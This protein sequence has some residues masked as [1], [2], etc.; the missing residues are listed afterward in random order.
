MSIHERDSSD[1]Y[2]EA[3]GGNALLCIMKKKL[4]YSAIRD[5]PSVVLKIN[6]LLGFKVYEMKIMIEELVFSTV[7]QRVVS[8]LLRFADK[9]GSETEAEN[10]SN[11]RTINLSLSHSDI[12]E[13]VGSTRETT[14]AALDRLKNDGIIELKRKQIFIVDYARLQSLMKEAQSAER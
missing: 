7:F 2:A 11:K 14:T 4:F 6:K 8:L 1:E 13:M 5:K 3:F 12:A 10:L 9:F